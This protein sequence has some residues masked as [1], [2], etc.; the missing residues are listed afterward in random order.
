MPSS[1]GVNPSMTISAIA[2]RAMI[3]FATDYGLE[4]DVK[5][6]EDAPIRYAKPEE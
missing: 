1:L 2:E 5:P 4:L 3:Y 6:L